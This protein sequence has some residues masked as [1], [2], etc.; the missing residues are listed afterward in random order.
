MIFIV[1]HLRLPLLLA[2]LTG[3]L[4][5]QTAPQPPRI[6]FLFLDESA[7]A[8]TTP[9]ATGN[10]RISDGP[11]E[12]SPPFTPG[13]LRPIHLYKTLPSGE[14]GDLAPVKVASITP[15]ANSSSILAII[16]PRPAASADAPPV[17]SVELIDCDPAKF[18]AG[19]IRVI[20]RANAAMA[21]QFG[22]QLIA[23]QPG[24]DKVVRPIPDNRHRVASRVATQITSGW[25]IIT[26]RTTYLLP[27]KRVFGI[28]VHSPSGMRHTFTAGELAE[29]GDPPPGNFWLTFSDS[30]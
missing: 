27:G 17:Y 16:S 29:L 11:Y 10:R 6:R 30:P 18:P 13:D 12:I 26:S 7:G 2:V 5:A 20:N 22:D 28:F 24:E 3:A 25:K 15:P 1:R 14:S 4:Q 21:G 8:Y 23:V 19:S 9:T